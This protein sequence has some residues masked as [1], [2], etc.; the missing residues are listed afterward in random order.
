MATIALATERAVSW[1]KRKARAKREIF[2]IRRGNTLPGI[3]KLARATFGFDGCYTAEEFTSLLDGYRQQAMMAADPDTFALYYQL[4]ECFSKW[5]GP[6]L[7]STTD[8]DRL[9]AAQTAFWEAEEACRISNLRLA[10][11]L[12]DVVLVVLVPVRQLA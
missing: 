9:S 8:E 10:G 6:G 4:A 11:K 12:E 2:R 5:E 3:T 1:K 7:V